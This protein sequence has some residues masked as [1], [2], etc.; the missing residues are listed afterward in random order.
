MP[1]CSP[2][3]KGQGRK[4]VN[5][6]AAPFRP[7]MLSHA[8]EDRDF[9]KLDPADFVAEWKWDGIRV[10][11]TSERGISRLYT[12]T[13][14]DISAAF[15]DLVDAFAFDGALDGELLVARPQAHRCRDRQL[16]RSAAAPQPQ[17]RE[18]QTAAR[19]SGLLP[20]L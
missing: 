4:P 17:D 14:D 10:Q 15:P 8:I 2:G 11:A 12:R 3:S 6:G 9:E 1:I 20:R 7:V 16:F 5:A 18:R 13:G 19:S